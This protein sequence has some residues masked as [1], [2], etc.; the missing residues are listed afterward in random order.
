MKIIKIVLI[1]ALLFAG[2][3]FHAQT[4]SC[5]SKEEVDWTQLNPTLLDLA[6]DLLD[7]VDL[8]ADALE[9]SDEVY[10]PREA[11]SEKLENKLSR[12]KS[13]N[14]DQQVLCPLYDY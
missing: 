11:D 7:D 13:S 4:L 2:R 12:I 10:S 9:K 6:F 1:V 3:T 5:S 8:Q 14:A